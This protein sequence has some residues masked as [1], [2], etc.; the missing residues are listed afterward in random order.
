MAW[1]E[2][3]RWRVMGAVLTTLL[4]AG[5]ALAQTNEIAAAPADFEKKCAALAQSVLPD[6]QI[7]RAEWVAPGKLQLSAATPLP[8][9]EGLP[10]FCRVGATLKPEPDSHIEIEVWLPGESWNGRFQAVGNG[11][12]AGS[13]TYAAMTGALAGGYA[14]ASTDTGHKGSPTSGEWALGHPAKVADFGYRAVHEMTLKAKALV[15]AFYTQPAKY[16]YWNGCSEGGNQALGEAQRYPNDYDGILAGAPA[17]YMTHLQAG[18]NWIS[19]A[20]HKERTSFIAESKLPLIND[21]VLAAC[22]AADGVRDGVLE[23]PRTCQF[24]I[25]ELQCK[26]GDNEDCLTAAQVRGLRQIYE[27][28]KPQLMAVQAK[29]KKRLRRQPAQPPRMGKQVF[30]G[31]TLGS[32]LEWRGWIAGTDSPPQNLQHQIQNDFFKYLVFENPNWDWK[33]FKFDRDVDYADQKIG[34]IVNQTDPDLRTFKARGGKLLH[35]HGWYDPAISPLNSVNYFQSV[36][37]KMGDTASFYRLFMVPGMAHCRGGPGATEFDP[38][39]P[40]VEWVEQG[41]APDSILGSKL[42]EGQVVRTRPICA[43][44]KTAKYRGSGSTDDAA[45][46]Q[47]S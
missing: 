4:G 47:C 15:T 33:T 19:Q 7:T 45:N 13:I 18:G 40:I 35:Y 34:P 1:S 21:A 44:P 31:H 32:E 24:D 3:F 17:N 23:D 29:K 39:A 10:A 5:A 12:L 16:S 11:G 27:G 30:P 43:F 22:D 26:G 36:R 25:A 8:N 6:T 42:K 41:K 20:I 46:F 28:V 38:M 37:A 2:L 9:A 14:T